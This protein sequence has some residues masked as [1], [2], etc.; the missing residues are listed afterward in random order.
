MWTRALLALALVAEPIVASAIATDSTIARLP[1]PETLAL[2][3][4]GMA[5]VIVTRWK[6]RK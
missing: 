2:L 3:A 5:A 1:E 6:K 4:I